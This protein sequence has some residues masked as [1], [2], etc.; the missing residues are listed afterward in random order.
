VLTAG[1]K[2]RSREGTVWCPLHF[3]LPAVHHWNVDLHSVAGRSGNAVS[4][5]LPPRA[6]LL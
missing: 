6:D 1:G 2:D 5:L 4:P 3:C